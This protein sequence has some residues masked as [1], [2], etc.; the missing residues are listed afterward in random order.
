MVAY[1]KKWVAYC[2]AVLYYSKITFTAPAASME[3]IDIQLVFFCQ[4]IVYDVTHVTYT[5][6][7]PIASIDA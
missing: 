1:D 7:R 3:K 5:S 2:N 4:V 6:Q